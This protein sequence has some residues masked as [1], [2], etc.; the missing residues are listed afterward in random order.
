MMNLC[1]E[2]VGFFVSNEVAAV[3]VVALASPTP[4]GKERR[5]TSKNTKDH[6][7]KTQEHQENNQ[8]HQNSGYS[9]SWVY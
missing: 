5:K 3:A 8:G 1:L 4:P 9:H 6:G 2:G 7:T